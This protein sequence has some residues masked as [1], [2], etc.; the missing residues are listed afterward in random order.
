MSFRITYS[1]TNA[2]LSVLHREFDAA[3]AKVRTAGTQEHPY[4]FR[5]K[6]KTSGDFLED[7]NPAM[8]T[9]LLARFHKTPSSDVA[10]IFEFSKTAFQSWRRTPW[11]DRVA[12]FRRAAEIISERRLELAAI[13]A[14]ETGKNRLESLGDVEES[15]DLFRFHCQQV[16]ESNGFT[17]P[18]GKLSPNENTLDTLRPYGTFVVVSPFNFPMALAAGMTS[19]AMLAGNTVIFKPSQET[20][21]SGLK[22]VECLRDAGLP[23][24]VL[25]PVFGTGSAIGNALI[26]HPGVDGVAFTGSYDIGMQI[27]RRMQSGKYPR[28][29]MLEMGGKNPTIVCESAN[30]EKAVTGCFRSAFGL[31][32]QKCSALSRVYV[33]QKVKDKF[34]ALLVEKTKAMKIGDPTDKDIYMGPLINQKA[35]DRHEKAT[36]A[37]KRDG[38]I[39]TGAESIRQGTLSK[40]YFVPPVIAELP[41]SHALFRDELFSPFLSVAAVDSL[42]TAIRLSNDCEYGLTAGIF[43]EDV[44]EID[45][46]MGDIE[47]GVLY[48]NRETGATTG[49]WPAVNPFC[50]WKASGASGKGI[51]GPYYVSQYA[52]EQSH[53]RMS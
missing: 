30:L 24:G 40:G 29:V 18:M 22:L 41:T 12:I 27:L 20:P 2:D 23:D 1:V 4:W 16:E 45:R 47:A 15:A 46:F 10:A 38:K 50:G 39:L 35:V 49:A 21:W 48:S 51:C 37:A 42:E 28:P 53:T 26:E 43:S 8:T 52:R 5:G 19:G 17:R 25:Q 32:G 3:L 36:A 33:H 7:R 11:K 14:L 9:D 13:M 34:L 44:E 6:P 31:T